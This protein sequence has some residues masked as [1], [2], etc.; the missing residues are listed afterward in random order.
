MLSLLTCCEKGTGRVQKPS[1]SQACAAIKHF[2]AVEGAP[3]V[4]PIE[5][6]DQ[7][8]LAVE[9]FLP[10]DAAPQFAAAV[11]RDQAVD[12][13]I[14]GIEAVLFDR[15]R[16]EIL[17]LAHRIDRLTIEAKPVAVLHVGIQT[18]AVQQKV[19]AQAAQVAAAEIHFVMVPRAVLAAEVVDP[20][21]AA[22]VALQAVAKIAVLVVGL[23]Q[24]GEIVVVEHALVR[25]R[26]GG[27]FFLGGGGARRTRGRRFRLA[28][29]SPEANTAQERSADRAAV[30]AAEAACDPTS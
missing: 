13:Q 21:I 23:R 5:R 11:V 1:M 3:R 19:V 2:G 28:P 17:E 8:L 27:G 16:R 29:R 22:L 20:A 10:A 26:R 9:Q 7:P 4:G 6:R 12:E 25:G 24:V 30:R 18:R 14:E 15:P